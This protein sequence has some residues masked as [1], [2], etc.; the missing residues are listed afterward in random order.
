MT[1]RLIGYS[2]NIPVDL[3]RVDTIPAP[4]LDQMEVLEVSGCV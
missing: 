1:T 4:L 2:M 3:S